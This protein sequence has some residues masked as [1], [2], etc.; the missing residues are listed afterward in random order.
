MEV[1][2]TI[3]EAIIKDLDGTAELMDKSEIGE[4]PAS[5]SEEREADKE[6][7]LT[8]ESNRIEA[9]PNRI[10]KPSIWVT[11]YSR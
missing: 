9:R 7:G 3:T 2:T 8:Q 10:R 1:T 6:L 4:T 11:E 5:S